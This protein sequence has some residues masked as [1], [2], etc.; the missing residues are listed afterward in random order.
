MLPGVVVFIIAPGKVEW[1]RRAKNNLAGR[2]SAGERGGAENL[3]L[4]QA[5]R[6]LRAS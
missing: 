5:P 2:D 3:I 6:A 4:N 1:V